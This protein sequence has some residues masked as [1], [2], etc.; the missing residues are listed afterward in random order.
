[1]CTVI[2]PVKDPKTGEFPS[3]TNYDICF[4]GS[5]VSWAIGAIYMVVVCCCWKNIAL[6]ASIM[7][8]SSQFVSSNLRIM[9]LPVTCYIICMPFIA[10]WLITAIH[11]FS[12]GTPEF[13]ANS[14]VAN[15]KWETCDADGKNCKDTVRQMMWFFVFALCWFISF[16][17]CVQQF[18]I[19]ATACQWYFTGQGEEMSDSPYVASVYRSFKWAMWYHCGSVAFGSFIIAVVTF[20]RIIFEYLV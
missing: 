3:N 5:L 11:L 14:F 7:E 19:A 6:G 9:L 15:V 4:Y 2:V 12:I 20:V 18:M 16:F 10:Y 17:V 1:M 13:K 8:C